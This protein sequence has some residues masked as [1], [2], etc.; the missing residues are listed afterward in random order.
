MSKTKIYLNDGTEEYV[1]KKDKYGVP[2][3]TFD[4]IIES[5][6][7][8]ERY[9]DSLKLVKEFINDM[10]QNPSDDRIG[11]VAIAALT[12]LIKNVDDEA[13]KKL[14]AGL[15]LILKDIYN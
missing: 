8:D 2:Y 9:D 6:N 15:T 11:Y 5:L 7:M 10:S 3:V 12:A 13:T 4:E 1:A 14:A